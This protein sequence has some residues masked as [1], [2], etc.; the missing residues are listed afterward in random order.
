MKKIHLY[1]IAWNEQNIIGHTIN[2][3][4][5]D[6][7]G[8]TLYDNESTDNT[9]K[10]ALRAYPGIEIISFDTAQ[11]FN[12]GKH[13]AIRNTCWKSRQW[14]PD[15]W[16]IIIDADEWLLLKKGQSSL[17]SALHNEAILSN[18]HS[19]KAC[20]VQAVCERINYQKNL[21][22]Q[23]VNYYPDNNFMK[24]LA[25]RPFF[26]R[27][28]NF[29]NGGHEFHPEFSDHAFDY[30]DKFIMK[31]KKNETDFALIH[32]KYIHRKLL[33]ARHRLYSEK[34]SRYNYGHRCGM[35][36]A[37][38][39]AFIDKKYQEFSMLIPC[40]NPSALDYSPMN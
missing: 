30:G 6:V 33:Y 12:D 16:V 8:I 26:F 23:Q 9:I 27:N 35:E 5:P 22:A 7:T 32:W 28:T 38:G 36:Y 15:D 10:A 29:S 40:A 3:Y 11:K 1:I 20:G 31:L 19:I 17:S 21:M 37:Y 13:V 39:K 2:H 24:V 25:F 18:Y 14:E 4:S 34:L